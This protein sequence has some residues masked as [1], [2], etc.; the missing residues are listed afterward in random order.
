MGKSYKKT[1]ITFFRKKKLIEKYKIFN[2]FKI[3]KK[4]A[5]QKNANHIYYKK[6]NLFLI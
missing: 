6:T 4:L 2:S 1:R 3:K 5:F